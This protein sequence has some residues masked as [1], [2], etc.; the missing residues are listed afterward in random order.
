[1]NPEN[2]LAMLL[3]LR[4]LRYFPN[5]ESVMDAIVR[6]CGSMCASEEQVRWLVDRMTSGIYSEWPGIAE[7]RGCFC[8]RFRPADGI[9]AYSEIYPDGLPPDPTAPP[10]IAAPVLKALPSGHEVTTDPELEASIQKLAEK[11]KPPA[12]HPAITQFARML[13]EIVTPPERR[14]PVG[15]IGPNPNFKPV[16]QA[17]IDRAVAENHAKREREKNRKEPEADGRVHSG[18]ASQRPYR[19]TVR[20][21]RRRRRAGC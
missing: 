10:R 1:M 20:R 19:S 5:D 9:N 12:P 11:V 6:L 8:G 18:E 15:P 2:V 3:E 4:V 7:M 21:L 16:T 17:D 13:K 14:E